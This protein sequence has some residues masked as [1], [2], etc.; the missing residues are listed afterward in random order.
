MPV[1]KRRP[2]AAGSGEPVLKRP[3]A[4]GKSVSAA[5]KPTNAQRRVGTDPTSSRSAASPDAPERGCP[6]KHDARTLDR[7]PEGEPQCSQAHVVHAH[8]GE[9]N[10][11]INSLSFRIWADFGGAAASGAQE[12]QDGAAAEEFA[13]AHNR[14]SSLAE[15][16]NDALP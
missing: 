4:C 3:A 14:Q 5:K 2:A 11:D 12:F 15:P 1:S 16:F 7:A 8:S 10:G 9:L 6:E 13:V